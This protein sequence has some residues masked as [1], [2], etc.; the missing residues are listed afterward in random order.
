MPKPSVMASIRATR[1]RNEVWPEYISWLATEPNCCATFMAP[2]APIATTIRF[3]SCNPAVGNGRASAQGWDRSRAGISLHL[4]DEGA[5]LVALFTLFFLFSCALLYCLLLS[6]A[7][8]NGSDH[9]QHRAPDPE[10]FRLAD[11][12]RPD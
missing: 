11:L 10:L 2:C 5:V 9:H 4:L 8:F 12:R 7:K 6:I 3:W 1:C